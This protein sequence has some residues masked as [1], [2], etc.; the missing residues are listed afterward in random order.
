MKDTQI[1]LGLVLVSI[2]PAKRVSVVE[3]LSHFANLNDNLLKVAAF[4]VFS[5]LLERISKGSLEET[6]QFVQS[7]VPFRVADILLDNWLY[8]LRGLSQWVEGSWL[9]LTRIL[10]SGSKGSVD[11]LRKLLEAKVL[12]L[13]G[14]GDAKKRFKAVALSMEAF[15]TKAEGF[16]SG[17]IRLLEEV[18]HVNENKNDGQDAQL[19]EKLLTALYRSISS[20]IGTEKAKEDEEDVQV[21][22]MEKWLGVWR[23]AYLN[24]LACGDKVIARGVVSRVHPILVKIDSKVLPAMVRMLY[25]RLEGGETVYLWSFVSLLQ[26]AR[27]SGELITSAEGYVLS[28][29]N[30]K[31]TKKQKK[32]ARKQ[33]GENSEG[34]SPIK[35]KGTETLAVSV[36][37]LES[38][39]VNSN[40]HV[41]INVLKLLVDPLKTTEVPE[42]FELEVFLRFTRC[43]LRH[44][45]PNLRQESMTL[46][47]SYFG[48]IRHLFE[49]EFNGRT[50][51]ASAD[52]QLQRE[53]SFKSFC[54]L[55]QDLVS[56]FL[57]YSYPEAPYEISHPS[58]ELL[59]LILQYF[60]LFTH[61]KNKN[62]VYEGTDFLKRLG[63]LTRE[64][65]LTLINN[66][67][68]PWDTVRRL[69]FECLLLFPNETSAEFNESD[70]F[71]LLDSGL[72][73]CLE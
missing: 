60:G 51:K 19:L 59:K 13:T 31:S 9:L 27:G 63:V 14:P 4:R 35:E 73:L 62:Q 45:Y 65:R 17:N 54:K 37:L 68:S 43:Y 10:V 42:S 50:K 18:M 6:E 48:R 70:V 69:S 15:G 71:A 21:Q 32:A 34:I 7:E 2:E 3:A 66:M 1:D 33:K 30:K 46:F 49:E 25:D 20:S 67:R 72:A 12:V 16:V 57:F 56:D 64:L 23:N 61:S 39:I 22:V 36:S 44:S 47:R 8:P 5:Q 53:T 24:A 38:L 11:V 29:A 41:A 55:V 40:R 58:H 52:V 26:L 28:D